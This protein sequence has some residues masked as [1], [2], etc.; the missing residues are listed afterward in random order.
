MIPVHTIALPEYQPGKK[1]D[2]RAL[3]RRIDAVL[4]QHFMGGRYAIR[5]LS[6]HEHPG[7]SVDELI[8]IIQ[9]LGTDRYDPQRQGDRYEN[10][11]GKHIDLFALDRR[12]TPN[13]QIMW[14]FLWS[15]D[16]FP[17][18]IRNTP[19][20][21]I[22]IIVLYDRTAVKA[23]RHTYSDGRSKSDGFVFKHPENAPDAV[24]GI[25]KVT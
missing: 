22:D 7:K 2:Y 6:S 11:G 21:R 12:V 14:Q 24:K 8:K 16:E 17:P 18:K 5:C 10:V 20:L 13:A 1:L 3:G 19:P 23:V 4:K 25:L 9:R 15:F